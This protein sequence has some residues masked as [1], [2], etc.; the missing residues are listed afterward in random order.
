VRR[1]PEWRARGADK[2]KILRATVNAAKEEA[3]SRALR[4]LT[5]A[6]I[7]RRKRKAS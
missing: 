6:E 4:R 5:D 3:A 1:S 7:E 2:E